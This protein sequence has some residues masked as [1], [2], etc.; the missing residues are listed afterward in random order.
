MLSSTKTIF[1]ATLIAL[2]FA[3]CSTDREFETDVLILGDG[4]GATAAA[5]ASAREGVST[6]LVTSL[7]WLGGMLTSAGVSAIDGNHWMPAGIWG[8]FRD[9]LRRY[10]GGADSLA[11]GWISFTLFEPKVGAMIFDAIADKETQLKIWRNTNWTSIIHE[12]D[13][14][15][16]TILKDG[17]SKKV[18][19]KILI[20]GTDLGDVAATVGATF[21]LGMDSRLTTGETM[22]PEQKNNMVQ[23]LTYVA[24][25]KD[26]H[27]DTA[28][29]I[30]PSDDYQLA[31]YQCS[32]QQL[33]NNLLI[34]THP[35]STML[36]YAKLPRNKYMINWP[37]YGNDYY[38]N[39][40]GLDEEE[41][42]V[43]LQKAK[44]HTLDFIYFIQHE[45]GFN[46]L[47]LDTTEFPTDDHLPLMPYHRE[48]RR[49]HGLSRL[50]INQILDPYAAGNQL[51]KTGIAVGDYPIDHHHKQ[52]PD[53]PDIDFPMVPSFNIPIGCLVPQNIDNLIIADKA[54]SVTNI[55]NGASRLQPVILQIGQTAGIMAATAVKNNESVHDLNIR[56]LQ[57]KL[58]DQQGY[59]M[60]Y[61]D[62]PPQH[63]QFESIQ[64]IGATGI[65]KGRGEPF[66]WANR[67]WFDPDSL[68]ERSSLQDL[69]EII[70]FSIATTL[71]SEIVSPSLIKSIALQ[72]NLNNLEQEFNEELGPLEDNIPLTRAQLALVLDK[73][74]H[75]FEKDQIG[76]DGIRIK[77]K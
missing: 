7:P 5:I 8:E 26:Y 64:K 34:S 62:V 29:E 54:I 50:N 25:L 40:I 47:G 66:Q 44:N 4:T 67:T 16:V 21:D 58:L 42:K 53:A 23:D 39:L 69:Y 56:E 13:H 38:V 48:G 68:A 6:L 65:L 71:E 28:P 32:C 17:R 46:H 59:L 75:V 57:Q 20:D 35:C 12:K 45:L 49:I 22:A 27:P 30:R 73:I 63:P 15:L 74:F 18:R 1:V 14:W 33:C 37:N 76:W 3:R 55:V 70:P 24:I 36:T 43:E 19:A 60:P 11:T 9:S 10:Y 51:Y 31:K 77:Q 2:S 61:Y 52:K 41:R 72:N